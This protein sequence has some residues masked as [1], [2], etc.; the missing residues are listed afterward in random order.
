MGVFGETAM[1][2]SKYR[3]LSEF[4][5]FY[6]GEHRKTGTRILHFTGTTFFLCTILVAAIRS[7]PRLILAGVIGA[8]G[9]AWIGH[10]FVE[11]NRPA[12]FKYPFFSLVSDFL[13]YFEILSGKRSLKGK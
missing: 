9:C 8:Y 10:F 3:T 13:F 2:D 7:E 4:Y 1:A 12:T 5:P 11:R 6:L